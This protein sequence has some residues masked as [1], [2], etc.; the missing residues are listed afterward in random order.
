MTLLLAIGEDNA[1]VK[2]IDRWVAFEVGRKIDGLDGR[3]G[4]SCFAD[5]DCGVWN[6]DRFKL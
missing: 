6:G 1:W 2:R 4:K 5:E 3:S